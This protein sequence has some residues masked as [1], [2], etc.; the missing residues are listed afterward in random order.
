MERVYGIMQGPL[1]GESSEVAELRHELITRSNEAAEGITL[2][3][4]GY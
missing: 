4:M 2:L 1:L 3:I